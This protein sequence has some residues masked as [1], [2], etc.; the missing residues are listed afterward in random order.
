MDDRDVANQSCQCH[1]HTEPLI[2]LNSSMVDRI[3]DVFDLHLGM[4]L[5]AEINPIECWKTMCL[6]AYTISIV[7]YFHATH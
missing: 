6:Y 7:T 5:H 2:P 4:S 3:L 1:H